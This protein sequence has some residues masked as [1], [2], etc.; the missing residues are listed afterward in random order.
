MPRTTTVT[1]PCAGC[2]DNIEVELYIDSEPVPQTYDAP[3]EG[4]Q[5]SMVECPH[6]CKECDFN[7]DEGDLERHERAIQEQIEEY[8]SDRALDYDEGD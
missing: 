5:W 3:G 7:N 2:P 6:T 4:A 8:L 1:V